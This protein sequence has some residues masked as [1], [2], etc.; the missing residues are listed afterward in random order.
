MR[1][2][3]LRVDF[4]RVGFERVGFL[5]V[6]FLRVGLIVR[7]CQLL[8]CVCASFFLCACFSGVLASCFLWCILVILDMH[9]KFRAYYE[10]SI[11]VKSTC[12]QKYYERIMNHANQTIMNVYQNILNML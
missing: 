11:E 1:V 10:T 9:E 5:R 12:K 6:G 8:S 3:F 4:V 7:V 2:G